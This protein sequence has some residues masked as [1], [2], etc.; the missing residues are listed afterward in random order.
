[1]FKIS[2]IYKAYMYIS[3][4]LSYKWRYL[5]L[6]LVRMLNYLTKVF[7]IFFG[8]LHPKSTGGLLGGFICLRSK[9]D[10]R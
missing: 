1:M 4:I 5:N 7:K 10:P 3:S 6:G 9:V 8:G 2:K